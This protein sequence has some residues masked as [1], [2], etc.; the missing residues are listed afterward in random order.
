VRV[1]YYWAVGAEQ[2]R[3]LYV[4]PKASQENLTHRQLKTLREIAE[5]WNDEG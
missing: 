5:R 2:L 1:T 3:M 4:Y